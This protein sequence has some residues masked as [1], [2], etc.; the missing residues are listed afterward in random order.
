MTTLNFTR[1][2]KK[3]QDRLRG[4]DIFVD[5][6]KVGTIRQ[7]GAVALPVSPGPHTVQFKIDWCSSQV[8][9]IDIR[10]GSAIDISCGPN[11]KPWLA[12][13][14]ITLWRE[15]Y[16]WAQAGPGDA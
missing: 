14:Y 12:L 2:L 4:Y 6:N 15:K 1:P 9:H 11:A 13:A 8:M 16:I 10:E 3:W 5:D 7:G